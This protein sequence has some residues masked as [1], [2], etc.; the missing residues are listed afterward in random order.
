M[1]TKHPPDAPPYPHFVEL[2]N[3]PVTNWTV[4][5]V[6]SVT[7]VFDNGPHWLEERIHLSIKPNETWRESYLRQLKQVP[8]RRMHCFYPDM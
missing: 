8:E 6:Y 7:D 3:E 2:G 1:T 4:G 5:H